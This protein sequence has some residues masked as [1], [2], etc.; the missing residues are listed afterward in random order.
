MF[1]MTLAL[2]PCS[3]RPPMIENPMISNKLYQ[4]SNISTFC[5]PINIGVKGRE[6]FGVLCTRAKCRL[7]ETTLQ[8]TAPSSNSKRN[9]FNT[10]WVNVCHCLLGDSL[11]IEIASKIVFLFLH[12]CKIY[13]I[14]SSTK[15]CNILIRLH[16]K[17][18]IRGLYKLN[19][20]LFM[21]LGC[22]V[23]HSEWTVETKGVQEWADV[24]ICTF[25][26]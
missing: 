8:P 7:I 20:H 1:N 12:F 24:Y 9:I 10:I 21:H 2:S 22:T 18:H 17:E 13:I 4:I 19:T 25:E 16:F 14:R 15:R 11:Y 3:T 26:V 5:F 6:Q 23:H